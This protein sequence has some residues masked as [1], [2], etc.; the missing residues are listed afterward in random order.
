MR[1]ANAADDRSV[2]PGVVTPEEWQKARLHDE[3][4]PEHHR[5]PA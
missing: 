2:R 4:P 5:V 1:D 3:H